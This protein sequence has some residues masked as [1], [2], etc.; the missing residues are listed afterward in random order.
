MQAQEGGSARPFLGRGCSARGRR[1]EGSPTLSGVA[2][3]GVLSVCR[4][5]D[6]P[7]AERECEVARQWVENRRVSLIAAMYST[8]L[9]AEGTGDLAGKNPGSR[10]DSSPPSVI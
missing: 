1:R 6:E 5:P 9:P 4:A 8:G 3:G 10:Q 7:A 2:E